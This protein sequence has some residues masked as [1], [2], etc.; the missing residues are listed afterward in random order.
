MRPEHHRHQIDEL[1]KKRCSR[2]WIEQGADY[3]Q[4]LS[5]FAV[6]PVPTSHPTL[7]THPDKIR[8]RKSMRSFFVTFAKRR[9][10]SGSRTGDKT[11]LHAP[12]DLEFNRLPPTGAGNST[13]SFKPNPSG[14]PLINVKSNGLLAI[15][16][17]S[18]TN[19][20]VRAVDNC[21][22][23]DTVGFHL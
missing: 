13:A 4:P 12:V 7:R 5:Y 2:T 21:A 11:T 20:Q 1:V 16:S 18:A 22:I 23:C 6:D 10:R 14:R 3:E 8:K 17:T 9:H 19:G 15:A